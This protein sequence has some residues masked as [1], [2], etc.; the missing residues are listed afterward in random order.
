MII[1][2]LNY[3][4]FIGFYLLLLVQVLAD[5]YVAVNFWSQLIL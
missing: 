5:V 1:L 3:Y 2:I 4:L